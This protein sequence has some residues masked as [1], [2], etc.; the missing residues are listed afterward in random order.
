MEMYG[1][2]ILLGKLFKKYVLI[3]VLIV[4]GNVSLEIVYLLMFLNLIWDVLEVVVVMILVKWIDVEVIVGVILN[5]N[6]SEVDVILYVI[7]SVLLI[8]WVKNLIIVKIINF[9][10]N[11]FFVIINEKDIFFVWEKCFWFF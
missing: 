5:I 2:I 1:L 8:S 6:N 9:C 11:N 3:N 10:I 4:L 7:L